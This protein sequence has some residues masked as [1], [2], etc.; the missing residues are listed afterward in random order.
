MCT[1]YIILLFFIEMSIL[2]ILIVLWNHEHQIHYLSCE[3]VTREYHNLQSASMKASS[4]TT[5]VI[6]FSTI[7]MRKIKKI[8][9]R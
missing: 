2:V 6:F 5:F 3:N 8:L 1:H 4:Y 9:I 7:V